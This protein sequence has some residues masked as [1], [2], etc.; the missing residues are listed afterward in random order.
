MNENKVSR[1]LE[2]LKTYN[3]LGFKRDIQYNYDKNMK[4]NITIVY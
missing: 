2:I 1:A 3:A 4:F